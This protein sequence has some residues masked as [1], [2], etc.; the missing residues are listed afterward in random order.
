MSRAAVIVLCAGAGSRLAP[1]TDSLPKPLVPVGDRPLLRHILDAITEQGFDRV[2]V[3]T[4]HH[5]AA[6]DDFDPGPIQM[7]R[8]HETRIL[9]TAGGV[10]FAS[11]RLAESSVVWNGDIWAAPGLLDLLRLA[12]QEGLALLVAPGRPAGHGTLG[13]DAQGRI[14]RLR[15]EQFGVEHTGADYVGIWAQTR[16]IREQLPDSGCMIADFCLP[17]LR[18]GASIATLPYAGPWG[19]VGGS[20]R[21]YLELNQRWLE[22][23][24]RSSW[25]ASGVSVPSNVSL[26]HVVLHHGSRVVGGGRLRRVVAWS[27]AVVHPTLLDAVVTP[28]GVHRAHPPV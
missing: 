15:G 20:V 28:R 10:R 26:E 7:E 12:E 5:A 8:S 4:H 14:V 1:L 3:N 18:S 21:A 22:R 11:P 27:G 13:L 19:D 24:G 23:E 9:G 17:R 2:V 6:F 25:V 16:A